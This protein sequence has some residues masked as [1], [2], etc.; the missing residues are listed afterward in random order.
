MVAFRVNVVYS[1]TVM[2]NKNFWTFLEIEW[3]YATIQKFVVFQ[4]M[5]NFIQQGNIKLFKKGNFPF[6]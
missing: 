1:S 4:E 3:I 5:N 6:K 2:K